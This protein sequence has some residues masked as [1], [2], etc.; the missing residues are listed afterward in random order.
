MLKRQTRQRREFLYK[1]SH[2]AV[3]V[4]IN[5]RKRDAR[6]ALKTGKKLVAESGLET[7]LQFDDKESIDDEYSR[8]GERDPRVLVT[9]SRDPS[10]RL[11][12]ITG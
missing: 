9:T 7:E 12:V 2:E 4:L 8:V 11:A 6:E 1:K 10:V 3:D 5:E